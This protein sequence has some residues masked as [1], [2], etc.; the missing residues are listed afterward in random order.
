MKYLLKYL[1]IAPLFI[2][3]AI[4]LIIACICYCWSFKKEHFKKGFQWLNTKVEFVPL[5]DKL[6]EI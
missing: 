4:S 2:L 5:L 1:L 6:I 3:V